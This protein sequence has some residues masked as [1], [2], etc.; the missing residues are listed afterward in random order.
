MPNDESAEAAPAIDEI[1]RVVLRPDDILIVRYPAGVRVSAQTAEK[2]KAQLR[3]EFGAERRILVFDQGGVVEALDVEAPYV[4]G[5][6]PW[7]CIICG[8][9]IS[10]GEPGT[11]GTCDGEPM[12]IRC[13]T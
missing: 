4:I 7:P 3:S 12:H 6:G 1:R 13:P 5:E 11:T 8:R 10:I 2:I 9:P